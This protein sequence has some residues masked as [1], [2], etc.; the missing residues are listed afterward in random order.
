MTFPTSPAT[1]RW[2]RIPWTVLLGAVV[3]V[4]AV[5]PAS[6]SVS[7]DLAK[8]AAADPQRTVDV[9]V[10][11]HGGD[12]PGTVVRELSLIDAVVARMS[13]AQAQ[14]LG[15]RATVSLDAPVAKTATIVPEA[16]ATSFNQ[17]VRAER[18]WSQGF[19][20]KGI[21]VAVIDTGI[22]GDLPDFRTSETD[23][24]SR[25]VAS[26]VVNPNA[27]DAADGFGH[28]T[29]IAGLIA[30]NG[31]NRD[32]GD[33]LRGRYAGVAP[34]AHLISI[35]ADDGHG[36]ATVAD[37]IDGLQFAV[38]F[39]RDY[40]IRV[41]NLSLR[42]TSS[43]SYR[44]D[45]LAAAAEQAVF[46]GLVVVAAAGNDGAAP[47][48]VDYAPA[49]DPHVITVGAVDDKGTKAIGD[50]QLTA[51]SSRGRTQDGV[52]KP[53]VVAPGAR[54]VSTLPPG[55]D[56]ARLCPECVTDGAYFRVGGTSMAAAVVSGEVANLL[57]AFPAMTPAHV[58]ATIT[59]RTRAVEESAAPTSDLVDG[60]GQPV[61]ATVTLTTTIAGAEAAADKA[62]ANPTAPPLTSPPISTWLD[63]L[64]KEIDWTRASW[65]RASWT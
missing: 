58:K 56:Y 24:A 25:V 49:N 40:G 1:W 36:E 16:L 57:Q 50:D 60:A 32:A 42:S 30:G 27:A 11:R 13:A 21:G 29:H 51:W 6:A 54:L 47:N 53:D 59:K 2:S 26:A 28:G 19:T 41:V 62:I 18:A 8:L 55:A 9:I 23:H 65:T 15:A 38:D 61:P 31:A 20:G 48:A 10:Q 43:E 7:P 64:T 45:P 14:A 63:P 22:A 37:V 52:A 12:V 44:T 3:A 17:S 46:A 33:A 39:R 34:D 35:K 5:A 4:F